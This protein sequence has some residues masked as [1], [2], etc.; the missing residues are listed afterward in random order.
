MIF[1]V[2]LAFGTA[3]DISCKGSNCL[4]HVADAF[5]TTCFENRDA[6]LLTGTISTEAGGNASVHVMNGTVPDFMLDFSKRIPEGRTSYRYNMSATLMCK[7]VATKFTGFAQQI[8]GKGTF[9]LMIYESG[10]GASRRLRA[11]LANGPNPPPPPPNCPDFRNRTSC[12]TV[13]AMGGAGCSWCTSSDGVH[14]LC[15]A[16]DHEPAT[17]W[18]CA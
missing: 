1:I 15:F 18:K 16:T 14:A 6:H 3:G 13:P 8:H 2:A 17:G 10:T 11:E 12:D 4:F 7:G 5:A 9:G